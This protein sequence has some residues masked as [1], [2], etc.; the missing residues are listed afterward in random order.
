MR[1]E[2]IRSTYPPTLHNR[3]FGNIGISY[4]LS[5][6]LE[7]KNC[8]Y[9]F[10]S[11]TPKRGYRKASRGRISIFGKIIYRVEKYSLSICKYYPNIIFGEVP[12]FVY[13]KIQ[14]REEKK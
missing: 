4:T 1:F 12:K 10:V 2:L 13:Y 11:S 9:L 5:N 14:Q 3:K 6:F 7:D 8:H